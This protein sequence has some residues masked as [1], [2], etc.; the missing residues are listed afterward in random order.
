MHDGLPKNLAEITGSLGLEMLVRQLLEEDIEDWELDEL[1]DMF[2]EAPPERLEVV[3]G[4]IKRL[5]SVY[6]EYERVLPHAYAY[7]SLLGSLVKLDDINQVLH[8]YD[9]GINFCIENDQKLTG[10]S[11]IENTLAYI[12]C[13][14]VSSDVKL[15]VLATSSTFFRRYKYNNDL[16]KAYIN[17]AY[18]FAESNAYSSAY[19]ALEDAEQVAIDESEDELRLTV[20]S[21]MAGISLLEG[22]L[23]FSLKVADDAL[24]ILDQK[25]L[26]GSIDLLANMATAYQ[27]KDEFDKAIRIYKSSLASAVESHPEAITQLST[28]LSICHRK[29]GKTEEAI[30]DIKL[31]RKYAHLIESDSETLLELELVAAA[32]HVAVDGFD[33]ASACITSSA[34]ALDVILSKVVRLHF[35][36]GLRQRFTNRIE[37]LICSLPSSGAAS[38]LLWALAA[39]R[40]SSVCDW[41]H[42]LDWTQQ[43][44]TLATVPGGIKQELKECVLRLKTDGAPFLMER[45]EKYDDP[46]NLCGPPSPWEKFCFLVE[47]LLL[48]YGAPP[49]Y[50]EASVEKKVCLLKQRLD[51][52]CVIVLDIR[53]SLLFI[54]GDR[55]FRYD[56]SHSDCESYYKALV[57]YRFESLSIAEFSSSIDKMSS[58]L[59]DAFESAGANL[60]ITENAEFIYMPN[61]LYEF[62]LMPSVVKVAE[63]KGISL[64]SGWTIRVSPILYPRTA[65]SLQI[66]RVVGVPDDPSK[67]L[68]SEEEIRNV[69]SNL[70]ASCVIVGKDSEDTFLSEMETAD[71]L[72][73]TTHGFPLANF[74][75]PYFASLGGPET[76]HVI[77][78]NSIQSSY[79]SFQYQLVLMNSCHSSASNPSKLKGGMVNDAASFPI[80]M[81][82]NKQSAIVAS[83]W[84]VLDKVSYIFSHLFSLNISTGLSVQRS[85][86]KA[87]LDLSQ[88]SQGEAIQVLSQIAS[89]E[90]RMKCL[91]GTQPKQLQSMVNHPYCYGTFQLFTL[92]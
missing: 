69:S 85:Y 31:A 72:V 57:G 4:C 87:V 49:P 68:L 77:S 73:I 17:A 39:V 19:R 58:I 52:K 53:N 29:T 26:K 11:L 76:N 3:V 7:N 80:L 28:N 75:D 48:E 61:P 43:I 38:D 37:P 33:E 27:R 5:I 10:K 9:R 25:G 40:N 42:L 32:N 62:S 74:R 86:M 88:L 41:M 21:V 12:M 92:F 89:P 35:R 84:R 83:S 1:D 78:T 59:A 23:D 47:T 60:C 65:D 55:Y 14:S 2:M 24:E 34:K 45:A 22:D 46:F 63:R 82:M 90:V 66:E 91:D 15:S 6:E 79:T 70:N 36:R 13:S 8:Y 20:L 67:L 54:A 50:F 51:G 18:T 81:L 71:A 16:I 56:L 30:D 44:L 64:D